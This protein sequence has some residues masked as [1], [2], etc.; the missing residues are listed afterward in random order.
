M[1]AEV[2]MRNADCGTRNHPGFRIPKSALAAALLLFV[3]GAMCYLALVPND[4]GQF[5]PFLPTKIRR[6][7][8]EHADFNNVTAFFVLGLIVF[9]MRAGSMAG[10]AGRIFTHW[11]SRMAALM[12]LVCLFEILQFLIPGRMSGLRD[13]CT[14]WSGVF[15]AWLIFQIWDRA[16]NEASEHGVGTGSKGGRG[17]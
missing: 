3:L 6:W 8:C 4:R 2:G 1:K 14:G 17:A 13:V 11:G 5:L 15:A 12:T 7:I 16:G 9:R 10:A